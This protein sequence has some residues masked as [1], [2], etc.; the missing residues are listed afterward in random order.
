M[1]L[2]P[3]SIYRIH[4]ILPN[5]NYPL[6]N[7]SPFAPPGTILPSVSGIWLFDNGADVDS[8]SGYG[9]PL[10]AKRA[11]VCGARPCRLWHLW[12]QLTR[13]VT[14]PTPR[15]TPIR[16]VVWPLPFW[17]PLV[18]QPWSRCPVVTLSSLTDWDS[19]ILRLCPH[20][21]VSLATRSVFG[22]E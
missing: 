11:P 2:S 6:I 20:L 10:S 7:K 22:T 15:P 13:S 18:Q 12:S 4:F 9:I 14:L 21:S 1:Q 19:H 17:L 8:I 16:G 5:W 3:P